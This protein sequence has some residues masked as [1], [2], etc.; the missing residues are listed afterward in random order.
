[1]NQQ[2]EAGSRGIKGEPGKSGK[3]V[4][5]SLGV[6]LGL[7]QHDGFSFSEHI[8]DDIHRLLQG[9]QGVGGPVGFPGNDGLKVIT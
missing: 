8:Y 7:C 4:R 1:M 2:G 3:R 6:T 9:I 5:S